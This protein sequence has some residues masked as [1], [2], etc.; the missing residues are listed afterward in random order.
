MAWTMPGWN[1]S[2]IALSSSER[3]SW[4]DIICQRGF[5]ESNPNSASPVV[6]PIGE[7]LDVAVLSPC[8]GYL[9]HYVLYGSAMHC[10]TSAPAPR[11]SIIVT[12]YPDC[13]SSTWR[14]GRRRHTSPARRR[15][16]GLATSRGHERAKHKI[17]RQYSLCVLLPA[18]VILPNQKPLDPACV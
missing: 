15:H 14:H 12:S 3:V 2:T 8:R 6:S 9:A 18:D 13:S 17:C 1:E 5:Q 16:S 4:P 10:M 7:R 11:T